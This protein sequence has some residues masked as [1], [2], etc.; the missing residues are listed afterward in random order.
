MKSPRANG[1]SRHSAR[2]NK[3]VFVVTVLWLAASLML[4]L[5]YPAHPVRPH[6]TAKEQLALLQPYA[7]ARASFM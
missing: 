6:T 4:L 7:T 3:I 1:N 2:L 5:L